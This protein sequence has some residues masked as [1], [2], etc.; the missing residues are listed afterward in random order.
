MMASCQHNIIANSSFSWW[1]AY[2]NP[3]PNKI[4][5]YPKAWHTDN[6]VRVGFPKEWVAL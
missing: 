4:V 5:V 1:A 6:I 3:N 2:L